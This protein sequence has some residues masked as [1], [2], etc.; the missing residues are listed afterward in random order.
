M[1]DNTAPGNYKDMQDSEFDNKDLDNKNLD[2]LD[3]KNLDDDKGDMRLEKNEI[4]KQK[5]NKGI[6]NKDHLK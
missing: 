4:L 1:Q 6:D 2:D 3:D 5:S